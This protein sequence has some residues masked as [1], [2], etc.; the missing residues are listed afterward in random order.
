MK[1]IKCLSV[2]A[3]LLAVLI[4]ANVQ[5]YIGLCCGKCGGNMPMNI[6]GGGIPETY[7]YRVRISPILM[8]M[9]GLRN[10]MDSINPDGL[11]GMPTMMGK[12]TGKFMTV[13]TQMDMNMLNISTGYSFSEKL[14][15]GVMLMYKQSSMGMKFNNMMQ[16][17]TGRQGFEMKSEGLA[18]T[19][20]M[21][22]FLLFSD[23]SLIPA[24]QS[25]LLFGVNVSTDS[26]D[27][28]GVLYV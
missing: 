19:M 24:R 7:E 23:D 12:L 15:G 21:S 3:G 14:F 5:A 4:S 1:F 25:L 6:S 26:I 17:T 8:H 9:E 13:P 22:K 18:D 27:E 28:R 11:P 10:G 2:V 16:M 20:L